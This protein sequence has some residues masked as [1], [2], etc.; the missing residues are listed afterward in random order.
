MASSARAPQAEVAVT[1]RFL[2]FR[3]LQRLYALPAQDVAEVIHV[4]ELARI[5]QGPPGLLGLGNLRGVVLPVA[6]LYGLLGRAGASTGPGARAIVLNGETPAAI[7]VDQVVSLASV[8]AS[9]VESRQAELAAEAGERLI[10]AFQAGDEVA[11]ILDLPRLLA[12][13]FT[14]RPRSQRSASATSTTDAA[15]ARTE[16]A[17]DSQKLVT[18]DLAGQEF[19][20]FL[21]AVR[22]IMPAPNHVAV[23]PGSE[24]LVLGV[25]AYRGGLLP[26]LSLRGL[27]GLPAAVSEAHA[28]IVVALVRGVLVGLVADRMR[29]VLSADLALVEPTPPLL[30]ARIG[31]EAKVT[32][33][34]RGDEGRRLIAILDPDQLFREDVMQRLDQSDAAAAKT[35]VAAGR[36]DD[37]QFLV[38]GLG[39]EEFALPIGAVD[40]VAPAPDQVAR[41][42]NTP[43]FLEGVINLRGDVLPVIDQRRRFGMPPLEDGVPRRLLVLRTERLRAGLIVDKVSEVLRCAADSVQPSPE[44]AG[45][46]TSLVSGVINLEAA[47]RIVLVL[48]TVELL[49]RAERGQLDAFV[50]DTRSTSQ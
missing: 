31:G 48:D 3:L 29:A 36:A 42:P 39:Q 11:H 43:A 35:Q 45:E 26:L 12:A 25:S 32:A 17:G 6:S 27:L 1:R 41:L 22:E 37:L 33:I 14:P 15:E 5:P 20:L 34:Y 47:G 13:S 8:A 28:S 24:A 4:P 10:G 49:S 2:T 21:E 44:I 19:A 9:E 30:A 38:F 40:E 46:A 16:D 50:A 18:F 23:T 7:A